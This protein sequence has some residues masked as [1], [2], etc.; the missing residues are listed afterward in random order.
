MKKSVKALL[1]SLA[2]AAAL[3]A[4]LVAMTPAFAAETVCT[5][6]T[7]AG[8]NL[9]EGPSTNYEVIDTL[10]EGTSVE[11]Y[12]MTDG[13]WYHVKHDDTIG[14]CYYRWLDF[15]GTA[16]GTVH[17]GKTTDMFASCALR[18]REQPTTNSDT[19]DV[20]EPE[21]AVAV[22]HKQDG[23]FTVT[24]ADGKTGYCYGAYLDFTKG[25]YQPEDEAGVA[26]S[27]M[28]QLATTAPLNVRTAPSASAEIIGSFEKGETVTILEERGDWYKVEY[29]GTE[30]WSHGDWLK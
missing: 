9:R 20:L 14:Y 13:G 8:L 7:T 23:W 30:G 17:D 24:T 1:G 16:D 27:T 26:E 4:G 29:E 25:G 18:V 12:G 2:A 15:E 21:E 10:P 11:V 3:S 28:N 19:I 5:M 6:A 22:S